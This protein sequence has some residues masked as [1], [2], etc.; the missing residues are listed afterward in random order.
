LSLL[1]AVV[2]GTRMAVAVVLEDLELELLLQ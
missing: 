2:A 1:V